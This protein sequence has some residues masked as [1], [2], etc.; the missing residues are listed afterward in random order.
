MVIVEGRWWRV[1][2]V[3]VMVGLMVGYDDVEKV[4]MC[5]MIVR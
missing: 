1:M 2:V 5:M 3:E 4:I